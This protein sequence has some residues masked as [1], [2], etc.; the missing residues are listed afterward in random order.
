MATLTAT[1]DFTNATTYKGQSGN[2]WVS[3]EVYQGYWKNT[4]GVQDGQSCTG[5][6]NFPELA[7]LK[8]TN[9]TSISFTI[10]HDAG[11]TGS[12][13]I[14]FYTSA[15]QSVNTSL[16]GTAHHSQQIGSIVQG[17]SSTT[18]AITGNFFAALKNYFET[19]NTALIIYNGETTASITS[20]TNKFS[21]NY[22]KIT[23]WTITVEYEEVDTLT[24]GTYYS[25]YA[26]DGSQYSRPATARR[27]R[28]DWYQSSSANGL[29]TI[30]WDMYA[31]GIK[32][33]SGENW[34]IQVIEM[35]FGINTASGTTI[36]SISNPTII[37][38]KQNNTSADWSNSG[39]GITSSTTGELYKSAYK[40]GNL[41]R[42][43]AGCHMFS[44]EFVLEGNSPQFY[45]TWFSV[46]GGAG[47]AGET[48]TSEVY[49][50]ASNVY[51]VTFE[52]T[53]DGECS[54]ST[55]TVKEGN[56]ILLPGP[57]TWT[58]STITPTELV[59]YP[60]GD[61]QSVSYGLILTY[62]LLGWKTTSA[63]TEEYMPINTLYTPIADITLW[64]QTKSYFINDKLSNLPNY[65]KDPET[66][67]ITI[68][69]NNNYDWAS[70]NNKSQSVERHVVKYYKFTH[71]NDSNGNIVPENTSLSN[72]ASSAIYGVWEETNVCNTVSTLP[73]FAK[74]VSVPTGDVVTCSFDTAGGSSVTTPIVKDVYNDAHFVG[75][76]TTHDDL[77]TLLASDDELNQDMTLYAY[78]EVDSADIGP[79]FK[80]PVTTKEGYNFRGWLG[81]NGITYAEKETTAEI[82]EDLDLVA[83][84]TKVPS[85]A[86]AY[87]FT[88]KF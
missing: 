5:F 34:Y 60:Y 4:S 46:H 57:E 26:L 24:S 10:S 88:N 85:R 41:K 74:Y 70:S 11:N 37:M 79:T 49:K 59:L 28:V 42:P 69:C 73:S 77:S 64:A 16:T 65:T 21:K 17:R 87:I 43:Y 20:G 8:D 56:S 15:Y 51:T 2:K 3:G 71:W 14:K 80:M 32:E 83:Q 52:R 62:E 27:Y 12:K 23:A 81:S 39:A 36:S 44:G 19:G 25:P 13:T 72:Y 48:G 58:P 1:L 67:A 9:I 18:T 35:T 22:L 53:S 33:G 45:F 66:Q 7:A 55:L 84:W 61:N 78:Y 38:D 47:T 31:E 50:L 6:A 63:Y 75:Y 30:K 29:R 68:I 86:I 54:V 82:T 76:T 40:Y